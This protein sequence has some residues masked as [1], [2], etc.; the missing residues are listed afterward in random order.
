RC[1]QIAARRGLVNHTEYLRPLRGVQHGQAI[2]R[3]LGARHTKRA[4]QGSAHGRQRWSRQG[5]TAYSTSLPVTFGG[6]SFFTFACTALNAS[7]SCAREAA[8]GNLFISSE[9]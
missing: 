5:S 4:D 7:L 3:L 9:T 6:G 2:R 1:L 8:A